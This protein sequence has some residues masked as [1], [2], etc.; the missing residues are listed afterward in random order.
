MAKVIWTDSA[1]ND[2]APIYEYIARQTQS[3][4]RAEQF[5]LDLVAA[6]VDRLARLPDSGAL[7]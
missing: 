6:S 4:D 7:V 2:L 1:L 3:V 5:C